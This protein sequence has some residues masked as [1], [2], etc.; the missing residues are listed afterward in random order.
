M[1]LTEIRLLG[2]MLAFWGAWQVLY[3]LGIYH[4]VVDITIRLFWGIGL[5]ILGIR[6]CLREE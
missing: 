3:L 5:T 6:F 4:P 1:T 2:L